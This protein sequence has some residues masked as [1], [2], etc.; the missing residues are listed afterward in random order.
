[1]EKLV[2]IERL[3][4]AIG[5]EIRGMDLRS[6]SGEDVRMM[7]DA[8][9]EH[10]VIF[11][12]N[13]HLSEE[14]HIAL[15]RYFG[16]LYVHPYQ[17]NE[18]KHPELY[19]LEAKPD[20]ENYERYYNLQWHADVTCDAEPPMGAILIVREI[21]ANGGGDTMW[22]NTYAAYEALSDPMK[23][24]LT[25]LTAIH[26]AAMSYQKEGYGGKANQQ[27]EVS[28]HPVVR[29]HPITGRQ[30]LYVN[31]IFTKSIVQLEPIES[32]GLLQMLFRHIESPRF[33]CRFKWQPDSL[34]IWDNRCTQHRAIGDYQ[35]YKRYGQRVTIKGDR[36]FY[37]P[38]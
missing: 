4:P 28:E 9:L 29:T 23:Q 14:E 8:L 22:C 25:G 17:A 12:R 5:A 38:S 15:G 34:A 32:D 6:P 31:S 1:M 18:E 21:P 3:T 2:D 27:T 20:R 37:R 11:F 7:R 24:F 19:I 26:G 16:D 36:P 33:H 30:A 35:G 10:G 13:Q